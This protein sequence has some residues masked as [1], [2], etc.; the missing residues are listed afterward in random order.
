MIMIDGGCEKCG[1]C[2]QV[3]YDVQNDR[4]IPKLIC[5][6]CWDKYY[7]EKAIREAKLDKLLNNS[8][9]DKLRRFIT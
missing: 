1:L 5:N 4:N 7:S 6:R 2:C 8:L 9:W 3:T